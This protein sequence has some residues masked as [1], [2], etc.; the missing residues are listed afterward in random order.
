MTCKAVLLALAGFG[1][2]LQT[3]DAYFL[4][5][6]QWS[7]G[8]TVSIA[9]NLSAT[10]GKLQTK[11]F[12]PLEDGSTSWEGVFDAAASLWNQNVA[13]FAFAPYVSNNSNGGTLGNGLNEV[14]FGTTID[15]SNL[16]QNT[17]GITV[18]DYHPS[19]NLIV[20]ADIAFNSN[21]S[22]N[23]YRGPLQPSAVDLRRVAA[24][25]L[26]HVLGLDHPD[27]NGETVEAVM[28][29]VVSNQDTLSPDDV[30]GAQGLYGANLN[31]PT[32]RY[33]GFSGDFNADGR[34]DILWRNFN[35]G[36]VWI[37]LM[38]GTTIQAAA[39]VANIPLSWKIVGIG[40]FDGNGNRDIVWYNASIGQIAIWTMNGFTETGSYQL[41]APSGGPGEWDIVGIADFDRTGLSDILWRDTYTGSITMWKS[42]SPFHFATIQI[43]SLPSSWVVAGTGDIEGNGRPDIILQNLITGA[44][45]L[46]QLR[47]D[48][49]S[50]EVSLGTYSLN[51]RV[52]GIGDFNGDGKQ[53]ILWRNFATGD[54]WVWLMNGLSVGGVWYA[55]APSLNWQIAGTPSLSGNGFA[56]VLWQD[57]TTGLI[58]AWFGTPNYLD[59]PPPFESVGAGWF[60]APVPQAI[61]FPTAPASP[62]G[63]LQN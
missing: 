47:N 23:S 31:L 29:S 24:H 19:N 62:G 33:A 32:I 27:T 51:Y 53:D 55:G 36:S 60:S 20:E 46:W 9:M 25:E 38:N 28:N 30:A 39:P 48:Q 52:A 5:G 63:E 41:Q 57:S 3:A 17:L 10:S 59:Q 49:P 35:N 4:E 61:L 8:T 14:F 11:P 45:Y 7:P 21:A 42:V 54:V 15:G 13:S 2:V 37:W 56:D 26:G 50:Q 22:W 58:T 34:Q 40:N 18:Y 44:V 1:T 12:F 6:Q 43:G 16:D